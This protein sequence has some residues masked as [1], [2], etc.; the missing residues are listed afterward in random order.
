[1]TL[2]H[3]SV[4]WRVD[5]HIM[6]GWRENE[7]GIHQWV[8]LCEK[9]IAG[10]KEKAGRE[11]R[12]E[13]QWER[14][15]I[16]NSRP[17]STWRV[18]GHLMKG[19]KENEVGIHQ[20]VCLCEREREKKS[21]KKARVRETVTK[22]QREKLQTIIYLKEWRKWDRDTPV[23]VFVWKI[24]REKELEESNLER[25]TVRERYIKEYQT[26]FYWTDT[27]W[28]DEG[29]LRQGYI[30]ERL[31]TLQNLEPIKRGL[32]SVSAFEPGC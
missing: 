5:G 18:D 14:E 16:R 13:R 20:W 25:E 28:R 1:M 31:K 30:S 4:T 9:E 11:R 21:W 29:K 32:I 12:R 24:E 22:K 8:C 2:S 17:L 6:K 26:I 7:A 10:E 19:C 15:R 27:W 23:S 3:P